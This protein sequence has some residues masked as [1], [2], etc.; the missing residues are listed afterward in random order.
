VINNLIKKLE[1]IVGSNQQAQYE[2][3][4]LLEKITGLSRIMLLVKAK[5][6]SLDQQQALDELVKQRLQGKPLAYILGDIPFAG[7]MLAI[8]PPVLIP[9]PETEEMVA[10]VI[11]RFAQYRHEPLVVLDMCTGSGC[12]ALAL[13]AA[14]P[15]WQIVGVDINPAAIELAQENKNM[16]QLGNVSFIEG[17]LFNSAP[18]AR[19]FNL[20]IS[21][22]PYISQ[23]SHELVGKDV[24]AWED[25]AALF[26]D[27]NGSAF[28]HE[29]IAQAKKLITLP[30]KSRPHLIFEFGVDQEDMA[31]Y[32]L[33]NACRSIEIH[34]DCMGINR[35]S[36]CQI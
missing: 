29:L 32:L 24:L 33:Q 23:S 10:W 22:P 16:L 4:L 3:W 6:L 34:K 2:A 25:K 5:P 9:R 15:R 14:F 36:G 8:R 19:P 12:I 31:K 11:E 13:A 28:Y 21:N 1:S 18:W 30:D 7:I 35:W 20:I 17:S 27:D 26:A